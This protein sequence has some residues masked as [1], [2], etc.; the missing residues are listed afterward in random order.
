MSVEEGLDRLVQLGETILSACS[1]GQTGRD[2]NEGTNAEQACL[3]DG[4]AFFR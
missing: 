1:P 3:H 2:Q 4:I